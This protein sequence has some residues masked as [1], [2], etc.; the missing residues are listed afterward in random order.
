MSKTA[1]NRFHIHTDADENGHIE[2][3]EAVDVH[4][5][6]TRSLTETLE[7]P[8]RLAHSHRTAIGFCKNLSHS[9]HFVPSFCL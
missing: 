2:V 3:S 8:V 4:E 6:H 5:A 7:I 1:L 9:I